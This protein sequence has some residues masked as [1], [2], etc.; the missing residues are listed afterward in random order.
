[1]LGGRSLLIVKCIIIKLIALYLFLKHD[2]V[3]SLRQRCELQEVELLKSAKKILE[4]MAL[5]REKFAKIKGAKEVNKSLTPQARFDKTM[6]IFSNCALRS[7]LDLIKQLENKA[8]K[9][10]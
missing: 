10:G 1:M 4:A 5:V 2:H 6:I 7:N 3:G 8:S 9:Q